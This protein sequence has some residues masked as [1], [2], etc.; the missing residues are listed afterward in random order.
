MSDENPQKVLVHLS[1][2]V[3]AVRGLGSRL[4]LGE[5]CLF[6]L[7]VVNTVCSFLLAAVGSLIIVSIT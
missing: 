5:L 6:I 2:D 4:A 7:H 3:P 1:P